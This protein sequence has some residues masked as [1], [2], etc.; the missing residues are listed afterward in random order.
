VERRTPIWS[1]NLEQDH[2]VRRMRREDAA[3][4][5]PGPNLSRRAFVELAAASVAG[6]SLVGLSATAAVASEAGPGLDC[7]GHGLGGWGEVIEYE[8]LATVHQATREA[9]P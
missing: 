5:A 7:V 6:A 8:D 1:W 4:M 2:P 9:T 3:S